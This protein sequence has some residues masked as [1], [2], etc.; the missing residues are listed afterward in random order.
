MG[1]QLELYIAVQ[2]KES[3]DICRNYH[4]G[5]KNSEAAFEE[6]KSNA[7]KDRIR[8]RD[9]I[10]SCGDFGAT[11]DEIEKEFNLKYRLDRGE[12]GIRPSTCSA[13]CSELKADKLIYEDGGRPTRTGSRAAV[14]KAVK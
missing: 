5:N 11:C 12:I 3:T 1:S 7:T 9:Y 2:R 8:I 14:L 6:A 10:E 4:I 13:R